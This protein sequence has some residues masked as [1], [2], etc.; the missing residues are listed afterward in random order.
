MAALP[1]SA[2]ELHASQICLAIRAIPRGETR[3]YAAVARAAGI[4]GRARLVARVLARTD[5]IVPWHRVVRADGRI[6]FPT[7][8]AH[9]VEQIEKLR[10][11]GVVL[12]NGKVVRSNSLDARLW[13]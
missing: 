1:A 3:S 4:P 8:S 12:K 9:F 6:A 5:Q 7:D 10:S 13:G 11:E 2:S